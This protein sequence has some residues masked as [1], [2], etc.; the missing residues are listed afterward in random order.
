MRFYQATRFLFP[1]SLRM[2]MFSICFIGTHIPL[3]TFAGWQYL[4]GRADITALG[5]VVGATLVGTIFTLF[6]IDALMAP[7]RIATRA[8]ASLEHEQVAALDSVRDGDLFVEL[9]SGVDRATAATKARIA[10]LDTA[11]HRDP[12]TGLLNRR[13]FPAQ[14]DG[15]A[16]GAVA[17]VDLDRFKA[18]NDLFGHDT[19]DV[20]LQDFAAYLARGVRKS[21]CVARWGGEEFVVYFPNTDADEAAGV[22]HRIARRMR[23]GLIE[24]PDGEPV[25][26]SA[27]VVALDGD[28]LDK[29]IARADEALYAAKR[30]GRDQLRVGDAHLR[31]D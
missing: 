25:T 12:L 21:D 30:G 9:L 17:L 2:R 28:T 27:G 6:C 24:R 18:V 5:V 22:L 13:G 31:V 29:A 1:N 16:A 11:A 19:G 23:V 26:C 7:V 4:S 14:V 8:V 15:D 3:L 20:V 10:T